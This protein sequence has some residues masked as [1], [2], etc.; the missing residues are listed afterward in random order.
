MWTPYYMLIKGIQF[1]KKSRKVDGWNW[2]TDFNLVKS[3][4]VVRKV[5]GKPGIKHLHSLNREIRGVYFCL[6]FF[7]SSLFSAADHHWSAS[8]T[9]TIFANFTISVIVLK[10]EEKKE[11]LCQILMNSINLM[12]TINSLVY[13]SRYIG[14]NF[15]NFFGFQ[16]REKSL[17]FLELIAFGKS[18]ILIFHHE[19]WL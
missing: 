17:I 16:L 6:P 11:Y 10:Q 1:W 2:R 12:A 5:G 13:H 4:Y 19:P 14:N 9:K 8:T 3:Y 18:S 15:M 7:L